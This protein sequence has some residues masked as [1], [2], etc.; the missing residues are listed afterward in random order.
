MPDA[1]SSCSDS[2]STVLPWKPWKMAWRTPTLTH[3]PNLVTALLE[4][5]GPQELLTRLPTG[6]AEQLQRLPCCSLR[7]CGWRL[8]RM[9]AAGSAACRW[10][11]GSGCCGTCSWPSAR[12]ASC[13]RLLLQG[14]CRE[15]ALRAPVAAPPAARLQ[16]QRLMLSVPH[17]SAQLLQKPPGRVQGPAAGCSTLPASPLQSHADVQSA[18]STGAPSAFH[19]LLNMRPALCGWEL[20][21]D[22]HACAVQPSMLCLQGPRATRRFG[23][24]L[25]GPLWPLLPHAVPSRPAIDSFRQVWHNVQVRPALLCAL[26]GVRQLQA[27][28]AVLPVPMRIP[29]HVQAQ[30]CP[31]TV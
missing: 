27:D 13:S 9:W 7:R 20:A 11:N 3:V 30:G 5:E 21:T 28:D 4:L 15:A 1:C 10:R 6:P 25:N 8:H 23:Q 19:L 12:R 16:A 29:C 24:V 31:C 14:S 2:L 26:R 17:A 18:P 22:V